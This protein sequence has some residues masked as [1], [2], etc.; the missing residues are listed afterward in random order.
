M[1]GVSFNTRR[2]RYVSLITVSVGDDPFFFSTE[3]NYE[4]RFLTATGN[5]QQAYIKALRYTNVLFQGEIYLAV[6]EKKIS[7][8]SCKPKYYTGSF[9]I[10][11][12]AA[13]SMLQVNH[14]NLMFYLRM[15]AKQCQ[16]SCVIQNAGF[17][18]VLILTDCIQTYS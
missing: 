10:D 8:K 4:I 9:Q 13:T 12:K 5:R 11:Q 2:T 3:S 6:N 1:C 16:Q 7:M 15:H 14:R 17:V 18:P